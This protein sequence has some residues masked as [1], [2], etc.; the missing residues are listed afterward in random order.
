M[1]MHDVL[2]V[3]AFAVAI[4]QLTAH[5]LM[6]ATAER[7]GIAVT[8]WWINVLARVGALSA[9]TGI[10]ALFA[11]VGSLWLALFGVSA[12]IS[13]LVWFLVVYITRTATGKLPRR[14]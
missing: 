11:H 10:G 8:A 7:H 2:S 1:R 4:P 3:A 14:P 6:S 13:L 5:L 12:A 9:L